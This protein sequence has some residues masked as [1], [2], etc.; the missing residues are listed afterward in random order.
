MSKYLFVKFGTVYGQRGFIEKAIPCS[1]LLSAMRLVISTKADEWQ[2]VRRFR[3]N[4]VALTAA[5]DKKLWAWLK[6]NG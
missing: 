4:Y 1:Y 6:K 2:I 5:E 3:K